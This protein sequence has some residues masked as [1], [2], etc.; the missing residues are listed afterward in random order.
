MQAAADSLALAGARELNKQ[1]GAQ[2]RASLA[3]ANAYAAT[4]SPNTIFGIGSSPTLGYTYV[5]YSSLGPASS[6]IAGTTAQGDADSKYVS[7]TVTPLTVSTIFP[8]SFLSKVSG[9]AFSVGAAAVA[10]FAGQSVCSVTPIFIC[11]PYEEPA[12]R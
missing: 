11:N 1:T 2:T 3:M 12:D 8:A 6:G 7:V 9:N 10:G 4:K 5:F